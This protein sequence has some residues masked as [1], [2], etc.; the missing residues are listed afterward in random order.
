[1]N[2]PLIVN[3]NGWSIPEIN[4]PTHS[5]VKVLSEDRSHVDVEVYV[6]EGT[7]ANIVTKT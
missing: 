6:V 2:V 3:S 1:M 7:H 5:L 4:F